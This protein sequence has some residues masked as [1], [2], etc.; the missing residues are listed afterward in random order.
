MRIIIGSA[1]DKFIENVIFQ[2][3]ETLR[4]QITDSDPILFQ[5]DL[6]SS[7]LAYQLR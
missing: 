5:V 2:Q 6:P 4:G 3:Q 7:S 1:P